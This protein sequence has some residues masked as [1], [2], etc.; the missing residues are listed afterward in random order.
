ML[1]ESKTRKPF[2][3]MDMYIVY[4]ADDFMSVHMALESDRCEFECQLSSYNVTLQKLP[5]WVL[6]SIVIK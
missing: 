2:G 3:V 4:C 1:R 5:T 6:A